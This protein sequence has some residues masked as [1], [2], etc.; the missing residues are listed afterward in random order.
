MIDYATMPPYRLNWPGGGGIFKKH[1]VKIMIVN[2]LT[3]T[4][5]DLTLNPEKLA[6]ARVGGI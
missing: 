3:P 2:I 1:F 6:L 5:L 4:K